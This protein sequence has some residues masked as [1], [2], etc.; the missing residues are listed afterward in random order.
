MKYFFLSEV[1]YTIFE[2]LVIIS[3]IKKKISFRLSFFFSFSFLFSS[4][5]YLFQLVIHPTNR[6]FINLHNIAFFRLFLLPWTSIDYFFR[7]VIRPRSLSFLT[8]V[9]SQGNKTGRWIRGD[10][11][12]WVLY[13]CCSPWLML[14]TNR[15]QKSVISFSSCNFFFF[16][17]EM[18]SE[19][20]EGSLGEDFGSRTLVFYL[21]WTQA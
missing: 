6:S 7:L 5:G 13:W 12:E 10:G 18:K 19:K 4:V 11:G 2:I 1:E 3:K 21:S 15:D 14:K 17:G 20:I 16:F 9:Y 8:I